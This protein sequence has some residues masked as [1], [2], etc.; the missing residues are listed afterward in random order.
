[1]AHGFRLLSMAGPDWSTP[2]RL[3]HFFIVL[4]PSVF[5]PAADYAARMQ[6]YLHDLRAQPAVP[7]QRVQAPGEPE[8]H[9]AERRARDGI[10]IGPPTWNAFEDLS[11]RYAVPLPQPSTATIP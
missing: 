1:M 11:G 7:G 9:E 4:D 2:R 3:G 6:A 10:P 5:L 8:A